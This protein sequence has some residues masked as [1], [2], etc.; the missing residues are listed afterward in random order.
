[1]NLFRHSLPQIYRGF[2]MRYTLSSTT[3]QN[4]HKNAQINMTLNFNRGG[5]NNFDGF[6]GILQT[7]VIFFT[8]FGLM[9]TSSKGGKLSFTLPHLTVK[10]PNYNFKILQMFLN[11]Q[12]EI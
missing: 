12:K 6:I 11:V 7:V 2:P 1:M 8:T 4:A 10:I 3:L 9:N 5:E